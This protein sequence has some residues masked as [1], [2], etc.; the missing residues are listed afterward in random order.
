MEPS[1]IA[2]RDMTH[3]EVLRKHIREVKEN[4]KLPSPPIVVTKVIQILKDPDL[5]VREL[6]RVVSDDP[7]LAARTLS[8]SRSARYAL[9]YQP[10]TVHEAILVLGLHTLRNIAVTAAAQSFM[11]RTG[12]VSQRL[13]NHSLA[14]ALASRLLAQRI[15]ISD[16]ETAFLA[17]LLHDIGEMILFD[18]DPRDFEQI[19]EDA[20][21]AGVALAQKEVEHFH[22][23]H[24]TAGMALLEFW[25]IDEQVGEAVL[26]HHEVEEDS[27]DSLASVLA[28]ADYVCG[29]A[30]LGFFSEL[31][32]P[33]AGLM[34]AFGCAGENEL[35]QLVHEMRNAYEAES[36]LFKEL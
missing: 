2:R 13:W 10:R 28:M 7:A 3:D 25:N 16:P 11:T 12:K 24:A 34:E 14:A 9:R 5:N 8:L 33:T 6:S 19:V 22:F 20:Q 4:H 1:R 30:D 35:D 26:R 15:G 18:S 36:L 31:P 27:V 17:G 23:D 21:R 32:I 29:K